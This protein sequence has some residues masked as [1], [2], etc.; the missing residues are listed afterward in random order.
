MTRHAHVFTSLMAYS[1]CLAL[2]GSIAK[3]ANTKPAAGEKPNIIVVLTDDLGYGHLG[4]YGQDKI[5]TPNL[6]RMAREGMRFT[7][8]YAGAAVCA[9]SRS[10]SMTGQNIANTRVQYFQRYLLE[11]DR[12]LAEMLKDAG[13]NTGAFGNG[14]W[15]W[16]GTPG[17]SLRMGKWKAIKRQQNRN[18][19]EL[20]NLESDLGEKHNVANERPKVVERM[21]ARFKQIKQNR[22]PRRS[23]AKYQDFQGADYIWPPEQGD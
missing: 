21:K 4:S 8:A 10:A 11:K 18:T 20:Y 22:R 14:A 6:D 1:V 17:K 2:L 23:F 13:Y 5:N 3:A 7:Q 16:D 12:T 19:F 9:P 15:A